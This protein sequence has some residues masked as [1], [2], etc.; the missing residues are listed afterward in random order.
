MENKY[1]N[2]SVAELTIKDFNGIQLVNNSFKSKF[3]L[4]KVYAPWCPHCTSMVES[5]KNAADSLKTKDIIV[6]AVNATNPINEELVSKIG[7]QGYPS[8]YFVNKNG[9]L[10]EINLLD[11]SYEGIIKT[12]EEKINEASQRKS[13]KKSPKKS[14]TKFLKTIG[15]KYFGGAFSM[16]GGAKSPKKR[17][18]PSKSKKSKK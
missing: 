15:V 2:S 9:N 7:T 16:L 4:V 11:R 1:N 12:V 18:S 17:R 8:F 5:V 14:P 6:G 13:P 3:G 10:E